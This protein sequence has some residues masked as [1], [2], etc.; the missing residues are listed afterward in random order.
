RLWAPADGRA[1]DYLLGR[2]LDLETIRRFRLGWASD[3]RQALR[4]SLA[5]DFPEVLLTEAGL[6]R[7]PEHGEP[8]DYFRG[9]I[10]FPSGDRAARNG[11]D[12]VSTARAVALG[13]R[14]DPVL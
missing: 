2:G 7:H 1:R 6:L 10:M 14:P 8:F 12:R 9:C 13:A 4:R 5:A 3:D 11:T